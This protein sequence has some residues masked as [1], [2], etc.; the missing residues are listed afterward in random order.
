MRLSKAI[1]QKYPHLS[2]SVIRELLQS[3]KVRVNGQVAHQHDTSSP[4]DEISIEADSLRDTLHPNPEVN[5]QLVQMDDD[6]VFFDKGIGVPSVAHKFTET[7]TA[8]NWLLSVDAGLASAGEP[9]ES[10]LVH[11]LDNDTSGL[12][13][14]ARTP[15]SFLA[16]K[17]I[18][19]EGQVI[20]EYLCV[21]T[22]NPP[23]PGVYK[24]FAWNRAKSS[25]Q[26]KI[27]PKQNDFSRAIITEILA[28][29]KTDLSILT[30][31]AP[32]FT[33]DLH[34]LHIKLITGF[35]HQIRAHL[36][37]LGCRILGDLIYQGEKADRL[38]L[39]STR[40]AFETADKKYDVNLPATFA[41][42]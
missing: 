13:V 39:K 4:E 7:Q 32:S 35:R 29:Q 1:K 38:Y 28:T 12:M 3:G 15:Q 19:G 2:L 33:Q 6:F 26:V 31:H 8:A 24:A 34:T 37:F 30:A 9:L 21:V 27:D 41:K 18:W 40:L 22:G 16:L 20:K 42:S 23:A 10:G 5:C 11:R 25:P 17:N 36:A 14:A